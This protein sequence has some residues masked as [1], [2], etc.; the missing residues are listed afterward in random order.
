MYAV[1]IANEDQA[2]DELCTPCVLLMKTR[3]TMNCVRRVQV[4][5]EAGAYEVLDNLDF[6]GLENPPCSLYRTR[7]QRWTARHAD[8]PFYG[9]YV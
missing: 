8:V 2:N 1:C 6:T 5:A 7:Q 9:Q 4:A 3:L